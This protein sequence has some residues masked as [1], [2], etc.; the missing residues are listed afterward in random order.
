M[1]SY[2]VWQNSEIYQAQDFTDKVVWFI[3]KL[4]QF[5]YVYILNY[6]VKSIPKRF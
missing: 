6:C 1:I 4:T 5:I 3:N 2:I